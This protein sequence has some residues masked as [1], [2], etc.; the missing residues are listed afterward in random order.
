M[1]HPEPNDQ[2]APSR[3]P[4]CDAREAA[5][6]VAAVIASQGFTA[7]FAGGCVRDEI[8]GITP[9]DFDLATDAS[10]DQIASMFRGARGVGESFGV[11]LVRW[12]GRVIEVATFRSDGPY[13]DGRRPSEVRFATAEEDAKRRDF[14]INGLFRDPKTDQIV[15]FVNGQADLSNRILRAIGDPAARLLEDRLRTLRAVRFAARFGLAVDPE[16]EKAIS[17]AALDLRA[18]SR[19]RVGGEFRRMFAHRSRALAVELIE[20]W[21]LDVA[22]LGEPNSKGVCPRV[23]NLPAVASF[24]TV[25]AA[26]RLDRSDRT[27]ASSHGPWSETLNTSGS[28]WREY[29]EILET[30]E[31]IAREWEGRSRAARKRLASRAT[32]LAA[33]QVMAGVDPVRVQSLEAAV[34][35]LAAEVG[36][37]APEPFV[38]GGD[39]ISMGFEPGPKFKSVLDS[40]YDLQLEGVVTSKAQAL[41]AARGGWSTEQSC[42]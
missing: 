37:L 2:R 5:T 35:L 22:S 11:M 39:L 19:E 10:P 21:G 20:K 29:C 42:S 4:S 1:P 23:A 17:A 40:V 31:I 38:T 15:D 30:I 26:W 9:T 14:T 6:S 24:G 28:E 36:G 16:T 8:L 41:D 12:K 34:G 7:Y 18:V 25:L 3:L 27:P 33:L 32:F 13:H